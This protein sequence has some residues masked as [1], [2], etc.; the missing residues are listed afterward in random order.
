MKLKWKRLQDKDDS[1]KRTEGSTT[2]HERTQPDG[3][4]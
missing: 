2:G 1:S 3:S 4:E